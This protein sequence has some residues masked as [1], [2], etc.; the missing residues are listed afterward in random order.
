MPKTNLDK[1]VQRQKHVSANY[2]CDMFRRYM[3][4]K[5]ITQTALGE[6]MGCT[7]SC[8]S[9][10]LKRSVGLWRLKDIYAMQKALGCPT[11]DLINAILKSDGLA[12]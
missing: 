9:L 4:E 6:S 10:M 5:K 11:E 3:A 2:M 8:V 1:F 7:H 12:G